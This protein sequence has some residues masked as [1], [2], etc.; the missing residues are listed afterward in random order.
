MRDPLETDSPFNP[1][2]DSQATLC[3]LL[4]VVFVHFMV[5]VACCLTTLL[6][7]VTPAFCST[8]PLRELVVYPSVSLY[9]IPGSGNNPRSLD[10]FVQ[11]TPF[12]INHPNLVRPFSRHLSVTLTLTDGTA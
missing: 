6:L 3:L 2:P 7:M 12:K 4:Y 10:W 9:S 8:V 5:F 1:D 11:R